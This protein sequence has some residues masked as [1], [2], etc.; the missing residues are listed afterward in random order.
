L[1]LISSGYLPTDRMYVSENTI[2]Q[3]MAD[4]IGR[5]LLRLLAQCTGMIFSDIFASTLASIS[6]L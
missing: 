3:D 4:S 6:I 1:K 2:Q 5:V